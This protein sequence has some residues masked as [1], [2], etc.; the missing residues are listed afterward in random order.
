[1]NKHNEF[2]AKRNLSSTNCF[3][4][5]NGFN[6]YISGI[7]NGVMVPEIHEWETMVG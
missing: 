2:D 6:A 3:S 7:L 1:M 4:A 5:A